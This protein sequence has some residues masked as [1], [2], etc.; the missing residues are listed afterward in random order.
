MDE[1]LTSK[2]CVPCQGE[3]PPLNEKNAK[4]FLQRVKGW[5]LIDSAT[6]ITKE[7]KFKN[8]VEAI[9]FVN[10]VAQVCESEGHHSNI[11]INYNKVKLTNFTHKING[12]HEND[13]ILAAKIDELVN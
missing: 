2:K 7:Y 4:M 12:L 6:K 13:F 5:E 11:E 8:F 1:T 3:I 10:K 9:A